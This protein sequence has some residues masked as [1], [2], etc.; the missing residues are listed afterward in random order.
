MSTSG[1]LVYNRTGLSSK[2]RA[3]TDSREVVPNE[4]TT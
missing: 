3:Q 2:S 4:E 1:G